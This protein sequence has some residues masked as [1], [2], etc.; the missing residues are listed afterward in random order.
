M[1]YKRS[2]GVLLHPTSLPGRFGIGELGNEAVSFVD[3]LSNSGQKLWQVFPLGPTGYGDSPYQSFSTFAGNPYLISLEKLHEEGLLSKLEL[4]MMPMANPH[5]IDFGSIYINKLKVL[6]LAYENMKKSGN[7][8]L[9]KCGNFCENNKYWLDDYS[10][11]MAVK[12]HHKGVHWKNWDKEIAFRENDA[13]DKWRSMLFDEVGFQKFMQ[14]KFFEHWN[15]IKE[16]ANKKDIQIIGDLP[17]FVAYDSAD[18]WANNSLFTI[19]S[20]GNQETVAGVPPDYFSPTGQLWG[21]PLYRWDVM[22]N[23]NFQ[24]WQLR[25][26]KMYELVDIVR[27]DHFRGLEAFWEV[28]GDAE[29]AIDGKWVKAPGDKL[30]NVFKETFGDIKILAEDLGVITPEVEELRDKF[31]L[32]G[33]KILQFGFG[34]NGDKNFL[35]HNHIK[36]CCVYT[37]SH[38][39]DTT[40]GFFDNEKK[41][42]SGVIE[43]TQKY[44]NFYGDDLCTALINE[45][46]KSVADI[47][48]IP[49]QDILNLGTD[50]RMNFP[51]RLG[52]NWM[53]RFS[54][55]QVPAELSKRYKTMV[56]L[57]DR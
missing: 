41:N 44:L 48:I 17:I 12:N 13:V 29:T 11:F 33:M 51:S 9:E 14:F 37:G 16:Y 34:E 19:D 10:L 26:K 39:N 1:D 28:P 35:P 53:W 42:N 32:P 24:W 52:G 46:Y 7:S 30:F 18:V 47:V 36:N 8:I 21:N 57:Y 25:L 31:N 2:S 49:M 4:N 22:E 38:D 50:A 43:W 23:D 40:K 20:K 27:I 6:R 55:D 15:F 56:K 54:W 5:K 3:F 45:A